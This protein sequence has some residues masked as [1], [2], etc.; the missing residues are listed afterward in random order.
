MPL[1]ISAIGPL[2][3]LRAQGGHRK[4]VR[5]CLKADI[6][7]CDALKS[8]FC[9]GLL[10]PARYNPGKAASFFVI[11][12]SG[13]ARALTE[14]EKAVVETLER[15]FMPLA[16]S[17]R[18]KMKDDG[19]FVH[20]TSADNA[21]KIITT[22]RFWMRNARCM[23]DYMELTFGHQHL[24][25]IFQKNDQE[26]QKAF[27]ETLEPLAMGLGGRILKHFDEWWQNLQFNT[28]IGSISE[29]DPSENKYGRLSMWRAYGGN[30]AKAALILRMPL[31]QQANGLR[32]LLSPVAYLG[33][34]EMEREFRATLQSIKDN[35][36]TLAA[37]KTEDIFNTAF[38]MLVMAA[39]S[40]KHRGFSEEREWRMIC[41]PDA[42]PSEHVERSVEV[43]AGVPQTVFKIPLENK[44]DQEICGIS[45]PDLI[46]RVIIGPSVYPTPIFDAFSNIMKDAGISD[47]HSRLT[48]SDIPLRT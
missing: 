13:G 42:L 23:N 36:A 48:I 21:V 10:S 12:R 27:I 25:Q 43:I 16:Y 30:S 1:V 38:Y 7:R 46:D 47:P 15:I 35:H 22:R 20:Y 6:R 37:L 40:L 32:V 11:S 3:P 14:E 24:V 19:R 17:K 4:S 45:I 29:H 39:L 28:Y 26:L 9:A 34:E 44:P 41:L 2:R 5:R 18:Q 31:D 8:D 33:M